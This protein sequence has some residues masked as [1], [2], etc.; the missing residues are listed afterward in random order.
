MAVAV[1]LAQSVL[2]YDVRNYDKPPFATFDLR[3]IEAAYASQ[4][5]A[6]ATNGHGPPAN[7]TK[8]EFSNDGKNLLIATNGSGHYILDAFEGHLTAFC[9]RP[10]GPTNRVGPME[11]GE[12][13]TQHRAAAASAPSSRDKSTNGTASRGN[14]GP[15]T[16]QGD[17]CF[18][19]DGRYV[20]G[21]SG[22]GALYVWDVLGGEYAGTDGKVLR[23]SADLTS[24]EAGAASVVAYNPRH[25]LLITADRSVV[26]WL[27]E[28]D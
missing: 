12:L 25:N 10:Q 3:D 22:P 8:V 2:L 17:A 7:W 26:F 15:T 19:P 5:P 13:R 21:G 1:P 18:S 24:K 28:E 11:L 27:P 9:V 6:R 14:T 16:G 23:P 4:Q 20:I